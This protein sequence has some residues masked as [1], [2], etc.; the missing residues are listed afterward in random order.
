M[1]SQ[2]VE[3]TGRNKRPWVV[4]EACLEDKSHL[5]ASLGRGD[6]ST[7]NTRLL[8]AA[9]RQNQERAAFVGLPRKDSDIDVTQLTNTNE[10]HSLLQ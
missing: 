9:S 3:G 8:D 5:K 7:P 6:T 2:L 1:Q 10:S 4:V